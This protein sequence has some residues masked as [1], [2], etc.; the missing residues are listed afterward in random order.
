S[1]LQPSSTALLPR[2]RDTPRLRPRPHP[3]GTHHHRKLATKSGNQA[4]G[5]V[6]TSPALAPDPDGEPLQRVGTR[7]GS[8]AGTVRN[9][10]LAK[11]VALRDSHGRSR[12]CSRR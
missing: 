10:L 1:V 2:V 7:M 6:T 9:Y 5:Q 12:C 3:A 8:S 11:G 4:V